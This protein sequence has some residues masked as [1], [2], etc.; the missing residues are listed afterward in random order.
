MSI[1]I[2]NIRF[3]GAAKNHESI[4]HFRWLN[5]ATG[6]FETSDKASLVARVSIASNQ[7]FVV[8]G[9]VRVAVGVVRPTYGL[10]YLRTHADGY[11]NDNLLALPTF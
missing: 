5:N 7:A 6:S 8:A 2:T 9:S 3:A 1:Q 11:W 10:P 4:S